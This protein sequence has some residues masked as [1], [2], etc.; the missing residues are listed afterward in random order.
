[1]PPFVPTP[2]SSFIVSSGLLCSSAPIGEGL[3]TNSSRDVTRVSICWAVAPP[4]I[5]AHGC[6]SSHICFSPDQPKSSPSQARRNHRPVHCCR[7]RL[8][9]LSSFCAGFLCKCGL[10]GKLEHPCVVVQNITCHGGIQYA[11]AVLHILPQP[12]PA[13]KRFTTMLSFQSPLK[14]RISP[15]LPTPISAVMRVIGARPAS[16]GQSDRSDW[17]RWLGLGR[18]LFRR[19]TLCRE[20]RAHIRSPAKAATVSWSLGR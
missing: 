12:E 14:R 10:A 1:M 8:A 13:E 7:Y 2:A 20:S 18:D 19:E 17:I 6:G 11:F 16:H 5:I 3:R 15:C 9:L 4:P